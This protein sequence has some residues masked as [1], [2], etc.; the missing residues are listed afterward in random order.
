M[1]DAVKWYAQ[2]LA[3]LAAEH[4]DEQAVGVGLASRRAAHWT[5]ACWLWRRVKQF[6]VRWAESGN[7]RDSPSGVNDWFYTGVGS[8]F[9]AASMLSWFLFVPDVKLPS[10]PLPSTRPP[11]ICRP[12]GAPST[13]HPLLASPP[14][15]TC[16]CASSS[17]SGPAL[18]ACSHMP[19]PLPH[20][21]LPSQPLALTPTIAL[22]VGSVGDW[23]CSLTDPCHVHDTALSPTPTSARPRGALTL[24]GV[25]RRQHPPLQPRL[26]HL[27]AALPDAWHGRSAAT[28]RSAGANDTAGGAGP[29]HR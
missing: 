6:E 5:K 29:A 15:L 4:L 8:W 11:P 7:T 25:R 14:L 24:R 16:P 28:Q 3:Q 17:H 2:D 23:S 21:H 22:C 12:P 26:H 10:Q 1:A 20:T 19:L 13:P 9:L 18:R 27:N